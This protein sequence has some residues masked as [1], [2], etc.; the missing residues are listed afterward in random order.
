[1]IAYCVSTKNSITF[2]TQSDFFHLNLRRVS[3]FELR[4]IF[5]YFVHS[6]LCLRKTVCFT[7]VQYWCVS[8]L[9]KVVALCVPLNTWDAGLTALYA[10][11][12][13]ESSIANAEVG[14]GTDAIGAA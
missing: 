11:I 6:D 7:T 9:N 4:G 12:F 13:D 10:A 1:M 14:S 5:I 2:F 3:I 8:V